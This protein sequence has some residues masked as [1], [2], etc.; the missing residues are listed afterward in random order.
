MDLPSASAQPAHAPLKLLPT[1]KDRPPQPP[2]PCPTPD[3]KPAPDAPFPRCLARN[4]NGS[5]CRLRAQDSSTQLCHRHA[6]RAGKF[7]ALDDSLDLSA[8]IFAKQE[9]A[10]DSPETISSLLS[11]VIELV[12]QGRLSPRRAA[13]MTYA[14]S[15]MLRASVVYERQVEGQLPLNWI[16][17][18]P[19]DD[20]PI[21]QTPTTNPNVPVIVPAS[22]SAT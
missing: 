11:N 6:D 14:F 21:N 16:P 3:S 13:V 15:L 18:R 2:A 22:T 19:L 10:Y 9:G 12:A 4:R 7:D 8:E 17:R 20:G 5:R 1:A